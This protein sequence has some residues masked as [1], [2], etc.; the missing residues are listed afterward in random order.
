MAGE[1][2]ETGN[3]VLYQVS[4]EPGD[5]LLPPPSAPALPP[6]SLPTGSLVL[7]VPS[8]WTHYVNKIT[9]IP[10]GLQEHFLDFSFSYPPQ[11]QV[12][13]GDS[14][15]IKVEESIVD[16]DGGS[17]TLENFAVGYITANPGVIPG[18]DL[19]LI[20]PMLAEQLSSQFAQGF[21]NYKELSQG[22]AGVA[23]QPGLAMLFEAE[24]ADTARGNIKIF[25]KLLLARQPGKEKGVA[26]IML[27]SALDPEVTNPAEVGVR[28][29]LAPILS[30]FR[31]GE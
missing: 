31:F 20:F 2:L 17:Y 28:G 5:D 14:N 29:D 13:P 26:I 11:F 19:E 8:D 1:K 21:P 25:G 3:I 4:P 15:F 12:V 30:S 24:L 10:P 6:P 9:A 22:P 27:A 23:G 18:S 16:P 7:S